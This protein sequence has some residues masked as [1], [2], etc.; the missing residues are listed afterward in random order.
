VLLFFTLHLVIP[1]LFPPTYAGF[2]GITHKG[3]DEA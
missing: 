3:S 2:A 1:A